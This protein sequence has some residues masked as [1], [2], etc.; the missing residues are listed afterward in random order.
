MLPYLVYLVIPEL[1]VPRYC[2]PS[3]GTT[4]GTSSSEPASNPPKTETQANPGGY[5]VKTVILKPRQPE[6]FN[7]STPGHPEAGDHAMD[8]D[9]SA[10]ASAALSSPTRRRTALR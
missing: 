2:L 10:A 8:V 1:D 9:P 3:K 6:K 7:I 5:S 4:G